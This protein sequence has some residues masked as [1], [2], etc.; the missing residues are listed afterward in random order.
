MASAVK[1]VAETTTPTTKSKTDT[2]IVLALVFIAG[3]IAYQ[4]FSKPKEE[5]KPQ[6]SDENVEK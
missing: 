6:A 5:A 2:L 3:Y 1:S 4:Y